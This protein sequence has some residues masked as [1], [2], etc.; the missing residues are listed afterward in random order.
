M[1]QHSALLVLLIANVL[2]A[3]AGVFSKL[4]PADAVTITQLRCML[5]LCCLLP[6]VLILGG[7]LKLAS[8]AE[9]AGVLVLGVLMGGHWA[10]YFQA[11]QLSTVAVG[12]LSVFTFPILTVLLE[13][14][15]SRKSFSLRDAALAF[16]AVLGVAILVFDELVLLLS[17][18]AEPSSYALGVL[19]GGISAFMLSVRNLIQKY[20]FSTIA[21]P[22]LM[23]YQVLVISLMYLPFMDLD[24]VASLELGDWWN[25]FL[26]A[27]FVTSVGHTLFVRSFKYLP[28]K[29]VSM[30]SC[31]QPLIVAYIAWLVLNEQPS[32]QVYIGGALILLVAFYESWLQARRRL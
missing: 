3:C 22:T 30:I 24:R 29:S 11:M 13:P 17:L 6:F 1:S 25:V 19:W 18:E 31:V 15:F 5:A 4:I 28:A 20:C 23:F 2:M 21:S 8:K 14:L 26:L 27:L 7:R 32:A 10:S 9:V 16:V 12:T